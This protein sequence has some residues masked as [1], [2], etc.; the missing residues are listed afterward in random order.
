MQQLTNKPR[1]F[2]SSTIYDFR[3]LRS[4]LKFWLEELG[5]EVRMSEFNDFQ[6]APDSGTFESCFS[7]IADCHYYILLVGGRKG[8]LYHDDVSVTQQEYR[9]A[10]DLANQDRITPL[11]FVRS[12]VLTA[13]RERAAL[14]PTDSDPGID[15]AP[16]SEVL[17]DP[18]FVRTFIEEIQRTEIRRRGKEPAG[19][20]WIYR[21]DDF[22]DIVDA[23]RVGFRLYASM[24]RQALLANLK[25]EL[26]ENITVLC[27]KHGDLPMCGHDWITVLRQHLDLNS[28]D[29]VRSIRLTPEQAR[30]VDLFL[31]L[32]IPQ[33]DRLRASALNDA[34]SSRQFLVYQGHNGR[35][36]AAP[37]LE[38]MYAMLREIERYR[39]MLSA[40]RPQ[41]PQLF[42]ELESAKHERRDA[43]IPGYTLGF[44]F[45]LHDAEENVLRLSATILEYIADPPGGIRMPTLN[46]STP[47]KELVEELLT[48]QALHEDV[49][50]W[51]S[52]RY[53]RDCITGE[54]EA[55]VD[56]ILEA[57]ERY[58]QVREHMNRVEQELGVWMS[59]ALDEYRH[60]IED[61]GEAA[62]LAWFKDQLGKKRGG[63]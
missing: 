35:L 61:E 62:A 28:K 17:K 48:E 39:S 1:V 36:E 49:G 11:I 42:M 43:Y 60:R 32:G 45:G 31:V 3:D 40:L 44:L 50:R 57:E 7:A 14:W 4:G 53:L 12:D 6:R 23:L 21:F 8:S 9:V 25:W 52:N 51:L 41:L 46:P 18:T 34:I 55:S 27:S 33:E 15:D 19:A 24:P 56:D 13:L 54:K 38:V 16:Q 47:F 58:P 22:R 59:T 30:R 37:E 2:V 10:S 26:E 5:L 29:F 63:Q 20:M